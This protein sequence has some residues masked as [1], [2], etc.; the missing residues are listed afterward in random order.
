MLL[1][2]PLVGILSATFWRHGLFSPE[3]GA[4]GGDAE[5]AITNLFMV[6]IIC[7]IT[8]SISSMREIVK[9]KDIYMRE[10]MVAL[11]I[12]PYILSKTMV[13]IIIALYQAAVFLFIMKIAG[14]WPEIASITIP[15]YITLF[16]ATMAGM[17][18][19]LLV[20]ALAPNNNVAP[21]LLIV[22]IVLQLVFGGIIPNRERGPVIDK[23]S[24]ALSSSTTTKWAF[25][26]L[27]T[28]SGIG[29]CVAAD[30]C[31]NLSDDQ[32][33]QLTE[34]YKTEN[35]TCMGPQL[36]QSC[37]FPGIRKY[38][39]PA[40]DE[41]EPRKPVKPLYPGDSPIQPNVPERSNYK[42]IRE[43]NDAYQKYLDTVRGWDENL[44]SYSKK[45]KSY[46]DQIK[47][48]EKDIDAYTKDYK[49]WQGNRSEAIGKAEGLIST[50]KQNYGQS[51]NVDVARH[52]GILTGIIII[53]FLAL[54][55]IQKL[56]DQL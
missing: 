26:S 15:V 39:D 37:C 25:E 55:A 46:Q 21:L 50:M 8:G 34:E 17:M 56:K 24:V 49:Q 3:G 45:T 35:C 6:A 48:Y 2:A 23:V 42:S 31:W 20:S 10:R 43:W 7:C 11:Q 14:G 41:I 4:F 36:F 47:K 18:Q 28:L 52:W 9:E 51:F 13:S 12:F 22:V 33:K 19:G 16:L 27:V 40:I 53:L 54:L 44:E 30:P 38:Y 29:K 1:I 5:L 32:R